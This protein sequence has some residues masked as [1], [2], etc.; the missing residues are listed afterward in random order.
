MFTKL[1]NYIETKKVTQIQEMRKDQA[2]EQQQRMEMYYFM[3]GFHN[4]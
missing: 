3:S 2:A 4:K 1:R